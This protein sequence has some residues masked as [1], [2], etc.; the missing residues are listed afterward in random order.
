MLDKLLPQAIFQQLLYTTDISFVCEI[1]LRLDKPINFSING[2]YQ[3]LFKN[4]NP[5][6][7]SQADIDFVMFKASKNSLYAY[8]DCLLNG[9]IPCNGGI[10]IGV[11]GEGV[12]ENQNLTTIKNITGGSPS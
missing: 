4:G 10:R 1:R 3:T 2:N 5:C 9:Y 11:V 7:C 8:N 6:I 12:C